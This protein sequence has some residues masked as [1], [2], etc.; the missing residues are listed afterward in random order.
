[1][2]D[3]GDADQAMLPLANMDGD[4]DVEMDSDTDDSPLAI[5]SAVSVLP[6][7]D[8]PLADL[9]GYLMPG[10]ISDGLNGIHDDNDND[11]ADD[12]SLTTIYDGDLLTFPTAEPDP[13][14]WEA[15]HARKTSL[16]VTAPTLASRPE[17]QRLQGGKRNVL[18]R[19]L[20]LTAPRSTIS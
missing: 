14:G 3:P 6:E 12:R 2:P 7:A 20:H 15:E 11:A 13:Y 1:M 19:F 17:T 8:M 4:T 9:S 16:M 5:S 10:I 18:H